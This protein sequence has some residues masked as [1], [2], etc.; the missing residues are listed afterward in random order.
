MKKLTPEQIQEIKEAYTR[1]VS[2]RVLAK[3]YKVPLSTIEDIFGVRFG[4]E[5]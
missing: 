3:W 4:A 2:P 5:L 1:G